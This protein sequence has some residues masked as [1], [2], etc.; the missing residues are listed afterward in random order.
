MAEWKFEEGQFLTAAPG[1]QCLILEPL[2]DEVRVSL[3]R[4][5]RDPLLVG[6]GRTLEEAKQL[7]DDVL[8]S[9][10]SKA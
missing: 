8:F 2:A 6:T 10:R 4:G 7:A 5:N 3:T 9:M 1:G